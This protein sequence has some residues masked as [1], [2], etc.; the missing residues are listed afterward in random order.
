MELRSLMVGAVKT[1]WPNDKKEKKK[2]A[3]GVAF[4]VMG[5]LSHLY[6]SVRDTIR[7]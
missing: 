6:G 1:S 4:T 5:Q 2:L 7:R 3:R